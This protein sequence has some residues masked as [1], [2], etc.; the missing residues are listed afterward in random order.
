MTT[1][2][3][4]TV[5]NER[6][7]TRAYNPEKA[8][9]KEELSELLLAAGKAPSAWNLQHWKFL[10]FQDK[11]IQE[12]LYPIAYNQQQIRDASAV[13]AVLGDLEAQKNV[14]E[15]FG[16]LVVQG[17]MTKEAKDKL[18]ANVAGAYSNSQY[19]REA[20]VCNASLAAMQFM[21]AAKAK[22]WDTC[23]IGGYNAAQFIETF[24][25]PSRYIPVMLI[26]IGEASV[27]GH[28]SARMKLDQ[29]AEWM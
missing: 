7:S 29:I 15:V 25:I 6:T 18:A 8:I 27:P 20:A 1:K 9:S 19:A 3:F 14:D 22:G 5:M 11:D 13:I 10:V 28:P 2:D 4:F 16:P 26:T 21:L 24:Q 23:P 17:F 12:K